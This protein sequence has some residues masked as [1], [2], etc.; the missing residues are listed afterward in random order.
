[1]FATPNVRDTVKSAAINLA[2][3]DAIGIRIEIPSHLK[4]SFR[5]LDNLCF[6]LKKRYPNLKRNVRYDD[7]KL[8]LFADVCLDEGKPWKKMVPDSARE[9]KIGLVQSGAAEDDDSRELSAADLTGLLT[10][11]PPGQAPE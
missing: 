8:E 9:A 3:R 11:H 1:M 6:E 5:H 7:D 10:N 2:G 4:A